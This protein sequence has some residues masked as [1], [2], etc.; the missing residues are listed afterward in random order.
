MSGQE[1]SVGGVGATGAGLVL[2]AVQPSD[3]S[4][5]SVSLDFGFVY[6]SGIQSLSCTTSL[7]KPLERR[8]APQQHRH[9]RRQRWGGGQIRGVP[10]TVGGQRPP[11]RALRAHIYAEPV[12]LR[13]A[14]HRECRH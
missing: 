11:R 5:E 1:R 12:P 2:G 10:C 8:K 9:G 4:W 7:G 6:D 14:K 3:F 13:Y